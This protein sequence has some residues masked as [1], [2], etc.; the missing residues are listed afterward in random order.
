MEEDKK[1][2]QIEDAQESGPSE[3]TRETPPSLPVDISGSSKKPQFQDL[4]PV[5]G[6]Y[7]IEDI[8]N[9]KEAIGMIVQL[10]FDKTEEVSFSKSEIEKLNEVIRKKS[11]DYISEKTKLGERWKSHL[12][13]QMITF[14]SAICIGFAFQFKKEDVAF[15]LLLIIGIVAGI[16]A[17][18]MPFI[19][20][21]PNGKR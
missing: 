5:L 18:I 20:N 21:K 16:F 2:K 6:K 15:W 10:L 19:V 13:L 3:E 4:L 7:K 17:I 1:K 8:L 11:D 12:L 9:N 14:V